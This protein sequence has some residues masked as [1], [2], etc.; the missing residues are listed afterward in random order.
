VESAVDRFSE[1]DAAA[2][3]GDYATALRS[4]VAGVATAVSGRPYWE[5]SPLTVRELFRSSGRLETLR[6]LLLTFELTVYG[7]RPVDE[8]AYQRCL[9]LAKPFRSPADEPAVAA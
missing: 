4:L 2:A 6:P 3:K 9:E 7:F 5:K 1:A 8:A